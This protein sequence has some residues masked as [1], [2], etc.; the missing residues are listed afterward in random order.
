[1]ER[2]RA[3]GCPH[4]VSGGVVAGSWEKET[5][6]ETGEETGVLEENVAA[7]AEWRGKCSLR[8]AF[9]AANSS[10][11]QEPVPR[12]KLLILWTRK[13][14]MS[15]L[16]QSFGA[17]TPTSTIN[18]FLEQVASHPRSN[19]RIHPR[20][21]A[22][23]S[24]AGRDRAIA[25]AHEEDRSSYQEC[26][27]MQEVYRTWRAG[28]TLM[29]MMGNIKHVGDTAATNIWHSYAV[30]YRD[31]AI[32]IMDPDYKRGRRD[33]GSGGTSSSSSGTR[34]RRLM[35]LEGLDLVREF[36]SLVRS[37][38]KKK[39]G[40][41]ACWNRRVDKVFLG[42]P[43]FPVRGALKCNRITGVWIEKWVTSGC[44]TAQFERNGY[45]EVSV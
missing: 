34:K 12:P 9:R 22:Y 45:E 8:H 30:V 38:P 14:L 1:M 19:I 35:E 6:E 36:I 2:E 40:G 4:T 31:G 21:I 5:E 7:K 15:I 42:G 27:R 37:S 24:K 44:E 25:G 41:V 39:V 32:Y 11:P 26:D 20:A 13:S 29:W 17:Q 16:P 33:T 23:K 10:Y 18:T 3:N 28:G 43:G